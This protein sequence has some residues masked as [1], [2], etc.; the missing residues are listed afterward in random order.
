MKTIGM[1]G[2]GQMGTPL[3]KNLLKEGYPVIAYD[4]NPKQTDSLEKFGAKKAAGPRDLAAQSDVVITVLTWPKVVEEVIAGPNGVLEGL[5]KGSIVI[6]CSSIDHDTSILL[7][8]KVEAAGGRFV[9][10]ALMGQPPE[11]EA[12]KLY[13]LTAGKKETVDECG[14]IFGAMGRKTLYAGGFGTAKLL[15]IANAMLNATETT[16]AYEVLTWCLR[17]QITEEGFLEIM[18]ERRPERA[19][20]MKE[21]LDGGLNTRPSWTAKDVYHGLK[22]AEE[23][24]IPTPVLSTVNATI[25]LAKSQNREGYSFGGMMWK[26]YERI[27]KSQAGR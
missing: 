7:A 17:N 16:I 15:K 3:A 27:A 12:K 11:I 13:F 26:F 22:V 4:I 5:K 10:A 19:E 1:I 21:I 18:R 25:N 8:Q 2:I 20:H 24:E 9:E 6:E 14:P 23:K